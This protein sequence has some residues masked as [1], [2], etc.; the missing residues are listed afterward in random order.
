VSAAAV[1]DEI[2]PIHGAILEHPFVRG[3]GDGSL[4][5]DAFGRYVVQDALFLADYARALALCGARAQDADALRMFCRHAADAIEVERD[6]HERLM[7]RLDIDP[8][9]AEPSPACLGYSSFLLQACAL[10]ER[11]EAIAAI[12]PCY[13]I[14]R[15]VGAALA[16]GGSPD[17]RYAAWIATYDG[18]EFA[19]AA[20]G[21]IDAAD[22]ALRDLSGAAL[23]SAL[24]HARIAARYE[25]MFWDS[26]WRGEA[27]GP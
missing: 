16:A 20:Q 5:A 2:A 10:R 6:L 22:R 24:R 19:A 21:A 26:A 1:W 9:G 17:P 8:A 18:D 7:G 27:W 23:A 12:L 4:P 11:H 25:W 13:W 14:Y 15:E 3:L